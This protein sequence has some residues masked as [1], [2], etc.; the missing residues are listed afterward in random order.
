MSSRELWTS[1]VRGEQGRAIRSGALT[2]ARIPVLSFSPGLPGMLAED[3]R[4]L[5]WPCKGA[6]VTIFGVVE[7]A[8]GRSEHLLLW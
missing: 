3:H 8:P 2:M 5:P 4:L 6:A 1:R 7:F